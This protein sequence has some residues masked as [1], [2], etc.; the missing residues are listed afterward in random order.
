ME[1]VMRRLEVFLHNESVGVLKEISKEEYIFDYKQDYRG[2]SISLTMPVNKS[3]KYKMFPPF[4]D[5]LLPEGPQL[6]YLLKSKK[7]D[8]NDYFSQLMEIGDDFVGAVSVK[9]ISE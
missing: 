3:Y 1:T 9:E 7:I 6:S 4:F 5:G 8:D 2:P